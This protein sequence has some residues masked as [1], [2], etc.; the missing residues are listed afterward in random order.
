MEN[1]TMNKPNHHHF[2]AFVFV[3]ACLLFSPH[4]DAR[5]Y[6]KGPIPQAD[7]LDIPNA[8]S[9][10]PGILTGGQPSEDQIQEAARLGY[11]TIINLRAADEM[12]WDEKSNVTRLG[13]KYVAIPI[14]GA[15]DI[16]LAN[17]ARLISELSNRDGYPV[18]IHCASG[19]RVG[20]LFA[21][22]ANEHGSSIEEAIQI[23]KS[24][25]MTRL[26]TAVRELIGEQE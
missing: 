11:K 26:E 25:G 15:G 8:R 19:N 3:S 12:T 13:M 17:A 4:A 9:P 14:D 23:G 2:W 7:L 6:A 5:D 24:A 1:A 20:A 10:F 16:T 18:L 21:L 22:D